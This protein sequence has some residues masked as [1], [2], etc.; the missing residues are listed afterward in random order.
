MKS[1]NSF[2]GNNTIKIL[3]NEKKNNSLLISIDYNNR[4][5][6][7]YVLN[8]STFLLVFYLIEYY[9]PRFTLKFKFKDIQSQMFNQSYRFP[10]T[11]FS[12]NNTNGKL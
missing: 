12:L 7:T 1:L 9:F 10:R 2:S 6:N 5:L 3:I 4:I 11:L 8:F